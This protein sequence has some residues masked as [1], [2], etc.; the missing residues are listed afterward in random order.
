M[1]PTNKGRVSSYDAWSAFETVVEFFANILTSI[2]QLTVI[3][4]ASR[5]TGGPL[6]ALLCIA[7]PLLRTFHFQSIWGQ[8]T[9]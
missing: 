8:G 9:L 4:H 2:S 3:M 7:K 1:D 6:F 5:A